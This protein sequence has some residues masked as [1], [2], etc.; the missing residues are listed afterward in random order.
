M[1]F[2]ILVGLTCAVAVVPPAWAQPQRAATP[3]TSARPTAPSPLAKSPVSAPPAPPDPGDARNPP[4]AAT[5]YGWGAP[6][7]VGTDRRRF[8]AGP[9][10]KEPWDGVDV[11]QPGFE[12]GR[13]KGSTFFVVMSKKPDVVE[14]PTDDRL[15]YV[16]KNARVRT[17]N[18]HHALVTT[19]FATPVASARLVQVKKDVHF[20]LDLRA[21]AKPRWE[22]VQLAS[23][24]H[25]LR[26]AFEPFR[27]NGDES[28]PPPDAPAPPT[29]Q[30]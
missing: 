28:T 24:G 13:D 1:R 5:G 7:K 4:R 21:P 18:N 23:G 17:W 10:K 29:P 11:Y 30:R 3:P 20:V 16:V 19:F 25:A 9:K 14:Q 6:R 27:V 8:V 15:V 2:T 12:G 22:T 26:V